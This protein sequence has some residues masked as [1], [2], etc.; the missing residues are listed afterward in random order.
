MEIND[1][2][3]KVFTINCKENLILKG[4]E[5][6][7]ETVEEFQYL[8]SILSSDEGAILKKIN[9]PRGVFA[10]MSLVH[11]K[12]ETGVEIRVFNSIVKPALLYGS[13]TTLVRK[14]IIK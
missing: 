5:V 2:K 10:K 11:K 3:S 12:P 4:N 7:L 13:E 1:D 14:A 6:P 9:K 8:G